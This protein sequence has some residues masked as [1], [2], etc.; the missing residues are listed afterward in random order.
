M[1]IVEPAIGKIAADAEATLTHVKESFV[2]M[3]A[4]TTQLD[5]KLAGT[6]QEQMQKVEE[7][8]HQINEAQRTFMEAINQKTRNRPSNC[9]CGRLASQDHWSGDPADQECP[10]GGGFA[11]YVGSRTGVSSCQ[12]TPL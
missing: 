11:T 6:V 12:M 2:K 1:A 5:E 4:L 8:I 9:D 3:Q 7:K 10:R